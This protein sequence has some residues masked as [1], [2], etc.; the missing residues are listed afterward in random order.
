MGKRTRQGGGHSKAGRDSVKCQLY[1]SQHRREKNK[2]KK[3]TKYLKTHQNDQKA[4][5]ALSRYERLLR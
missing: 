2:I 1:R 5:E 3:L 4:V